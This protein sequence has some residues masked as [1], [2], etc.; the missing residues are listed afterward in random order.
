M[1]A[2]L[3]E[4]A[5]CQRQ[6]VERGHL[7]A[8]HPSATFCEQRASAGPATKLKAAAKRAARE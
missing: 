6:A 7:H 1:R 8:R 4:F 3:G 2:R 5:G